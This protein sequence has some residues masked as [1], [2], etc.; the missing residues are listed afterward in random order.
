MKIT[1]KSWNEYTKKLSQLN[2]KAGTLMREYI[3]NHGTDDTKALMD[4]AMAL[5]QKYG[6]GSAELACQMYDSMAEMAGVSLPA[7]EPAE[8]ASYKEVAK[9]V[10]ATKESPLQM[11]RAVS[12]MVKRAGADTTLKNAI[13]DKAEFAWVPHGDTCS[14]CITLAS[15]G[16]QRASEDVL[17]GNHAEHIHSNCDCEYAI[18]FSKNT[19]VEGYDPDKYLEQYKNAD[20][21][22]TQA[23]INAMRRENYAKNKDSINARKRELYAEEKVEKK[24]L[25]LA[26]Q[27]N[28]FV[29]KTDALYDYS[30]R[31]KPIEG[32]EDIVSHGDP[33]SL[34]FIDSRGIE[35]NISA[36]EICDIIEQAGVYKGGNIRLIACQTGAGEGIVPTYIAKHFGIEVLA[37]TEIVNVD[38]EGNMILADNVEDARMGIETGRWVLFNA[39]GRVK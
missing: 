26:K 1:A 35:S 9:M 31:I 11:G 14:F 16:W 32:Y 17:K 13:R 7:A 36:K 3:G 20:G 21:K 5:I 23:K 4:Y 34:V 33:Y 8:V 38:F 22:N 39:K 15:R 25:Q 37:P 2:Q 30:R 29:V 18:R 12:R 28:T 10:N 24:I 19:D 27:G 6:E